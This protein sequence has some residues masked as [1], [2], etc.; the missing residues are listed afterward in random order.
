MQSYYQE[1]PVVY[2]HGPVQM[3]QKNSAPSFMF[4]HPLASSL[5]PSMTM[6]SSSASYS[7]SELADSDIEDDE[8]LFEEENARNSEAMSGRS[9]S[10][11][12]VSTI[13][14][15]MTPDS[16]RQSALIAPFG[17][18]AGNS[19]P[20]PSMT[21][22]PKGPHLF[23][24]DQTFSPTDEVLEMSPMGKTFV[25]QQMVT[26]TTAMLN[27]Y[28]MQQQ[29]QQ[30]S[31]FSPVPAPD[32]VPLSR[33]PSPPQQL[34]Q[35]PSTSSFSMSSSPHDSA[36][37]TSSMIIDFSTV[38]GWSAAEVG[39]WMYTLGFEDTIVDRFQLHDITGSVLLELKFD[40]LKELGIQSFGKRHEIWNH[41]CV[42]RGVDPQLSGAYPQ[43]QTNNNSFI[44]RHEVPLSATPS[45]QGAFVWPPVGVSNP[46]PVS[47]LR[48][49]DEC[50]SPVSRI[51]PS[52]AQTAL[53]DPIASPVTATAINAGR[54]SR[55]ANNELRPEDS[56]SIVAIEQL[57]PKPHSCSKGERCAKYR[58]QQ[59]LLKRL[60]EEHGIVIPHME[61]PARIVI[62]DQR[63]LPQIRT[64]FTPRDKIHLA[65]PVT[66]KPVLG[67]TPISASDIGPSLVASSDV[68]GP[69]QMPELQLQEAH[70]KKVLERD[71][72]ENVKHFLAMQH[73]EPPQQAE[74]VPSSDDEREDQVVE[75]PVQ[76][77]QQQ[78]QILTVE[79]LVSPPLMF[80]QMVSPSK[81]A[82]PMLPRLKIP[83]PRYRPEVEEVVASPRK[84]LP[85]PKPA[86]TQPV[87]PQISYHSLSPHT[88]EMTPPSADNATIVFRFGTPSSDLPRSP[89]SRE[90]TRSVPPSK[91]YWD[92]VPR[93]ATTIP[94]I[95][96]VPTLPRL[97]EERANEA[98]SSSSSSR[99]EDSS[100]PATSADSS[101]VVAKAT[102]AAASASGFFR[103][104]D[105]Q[106]AY[107]GVRHLG[108]VK[109]RKTKFLRHEWQDRHMRL[110]DGTLSLH[111]NA[112]PSCTPVDRVNIDDYTVACSGSR[113]NKLADKLKNLCFTSSTSSSAHV[114]SPSMASF[115]FQL[116][117]TA[118]GSETVPA[119]RL[120]R[121]LIGSS[122]KG[123][124][125]SVN[126]SDERIE[127]MREIMLAKALRAKG[128]N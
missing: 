87:F 10:Q 81:S 104:T 34:H 84:V 3:M 12:T 72:Q 44:S 23:W 117:A 116:V 85:T 18:V 52:P 8:S 74:A 21:S 64:S 58:R 15:I 120:Q 32:P 29:Q 80:S 54:L 6:S 96:R 101:P 83:E 47:Q 123:H 82:Q 49:S 86:Q 16:A 48:H 75:R 106:E 113:T 69:G 124:N 102:V 88:R 5:T 22:G 110:Q 114:T 1:S 60:Q 20:R 112:L 42:L 108:W 57:L 95:R 9:R 98:T 89:L 11:I 35:K 111:S 118:P 126:N 59:R 33:Q 38:Q 31:Q 41:I 121:T 40:D 62:P 25:D 36:V 91:V 63:A 70:L 105:P 24:A 43:S 94:S 122:G 2:H 103:P 65:T 128:D 7:S 51:G 50:F 115:P 73:I 30:Q 71:P 68:L 78:Q 79:E 45:N 125:F 46:T 100:T 93:S 77:Q 76:Q 92:V 99:G 53:Y 28:Y 26:P 56:A 27:E 109:K 61:E 19:P 67:L 127:W 97:D 4:S 55:A 119:T 13:S 17:V 37:N 14:E 39:H 66:A 90:A 107:P